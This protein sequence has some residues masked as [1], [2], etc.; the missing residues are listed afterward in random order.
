M[1]PIWRRLPTDLTR[2]VLSLADLPIDTRLHFKLP[3]RK[4]LFNNKFQNFRNNLVY[5]NE[6]RT[7]WD[8]RSMAASEIPFFLKRK[9][10]K[11]SCFRSPDVN[12]F[13][14]GWEPYEFTMFSSQYEY[15]PF[16]VSN[17]LVIRDKIKFTN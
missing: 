4:L 17:H 13:N 10:F 1:D 12:V 6:S 3:N 11:F 8:F 14:I 9:N 16:E 2:S 5:D 7:L 15:G